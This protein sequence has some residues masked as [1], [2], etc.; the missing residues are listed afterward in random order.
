MGAPV[1]VGTSGRAPHTGYE[2]TRPARRSPLAGRKG[3]VR[4]PTPLH[5]PSNASSSAWLWPHLAR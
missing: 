2:L 3:D 1:N 5:I 4:A